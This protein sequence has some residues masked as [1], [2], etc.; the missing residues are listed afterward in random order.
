MSRLDPKGF[1]AFIL[2][3]L[4]AAEAAGAERARR[5]H[6]SRGS[7]MQRIIV[8]NFNQLQIAAVE[9]VKLANERGGEDNVTV[10]VASFTG[11]GLSD[12]GE[13]KVPTLEIPKQKRSWWRF[14]LRRR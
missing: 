13:T 1:L 5:E 2:V 12:T 4:V 7:D 3:G 6:P 11:D 9:L 14:W 8:E 10:I